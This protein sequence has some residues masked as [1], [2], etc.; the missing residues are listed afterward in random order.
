MSQFINFEADASDSDVSEND[1]C[2]DMESFINDDTE[3]E[4][5]SESENFEF[6]NVTRTIEDIN[7]EI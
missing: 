7:R 2:S 5:E 4:Y 1:T 6:E 3:S